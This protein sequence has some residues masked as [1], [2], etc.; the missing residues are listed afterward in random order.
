MTIASKCECGYGGYCNGRKECIKTLSSQPSQEETQLCQH[1]G[2]PSVEYLGKEIL[3]CTECLP[4]HYK[5]EK[6]EKGAELDIW[7]NLYNRIKGLCDSDK[8][9]LAVMQVIQFEFDLVPKEQFRSEAIKVL[10]G[11]KYN[12]HDLECAGMGRAISILQ[13]LNK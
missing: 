10:E 5:E 12:V 11:L 2:K 13:S 3:C 7:Q 8:S 9:A 1:C 6:T 4:R